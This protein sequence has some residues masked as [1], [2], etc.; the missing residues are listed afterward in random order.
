MKTHFAK[1]EKELIKE[2]NNKLNNKVINIDDLKAEVARLI[3]DN[4]L[5]MCRNRTSDK[6]FDYILK[7]KNIEM[8]ISIQIIKEEQ[9]KITGTY[10]NEF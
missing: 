4:E 5:K 6:R 2:L 7:F 9:Y 10:W 1:K 3:G 8:G